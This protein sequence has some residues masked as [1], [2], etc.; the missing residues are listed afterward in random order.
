MSF[1]SFCVSLWSVCVLNFAGEGQVGPWHVGLLGM[2]PV[3]PFSNP[4]M[5]SSK[6]NLPCLQFLF[7]KSR[8]VSQVSAFWLQ[9]YKPSSSR[10]CFVCTQSI[11]IL[12]LKHCFSLGRVVNTCEIW[13]W[14]LLSDNRWKNNVFPSNVWPEMTYK[15]QG[16]KCYNTIMP[17]GAGLE[18]QHIWRSK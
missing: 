7:I 14:K 6:L 17:L 11:K 3:G 15:Q 16:Y 5:L 4:S 8:S 10:V 18:S 13:G 1:W 2:C 12:D 9:L